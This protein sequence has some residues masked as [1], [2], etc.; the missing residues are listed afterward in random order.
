MISDQKLPKSIKKSAL[1]LYNHFNKFLEIQELDKKTQETMALIFEQ[2][3]DENKI[4]NSETESE[5]VKSTDALDY[6][7]QKLDT[8][9]FKQE[10][11]Q[12][13]GHEL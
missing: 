2:I 6:E 1:E 5:E 3:D 7:K 4:E 12:L 11:N 13:T 8:L 9:L 10:T